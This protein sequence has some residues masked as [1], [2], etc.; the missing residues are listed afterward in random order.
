[1]GRKFHQLPSDLADRYRV[2]ATLGE[3]ADHYGASS[4]TIR[5]WMSRLGIER[6]HKGKPPR[7]DPQEVVDA[8]LFGES[9]AS[10]HRRTGGQGRR[11]RH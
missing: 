2:G 6:R 5:N 7:C 1:M 3:L 9:M 10:I 8:Y 11:C 4:S